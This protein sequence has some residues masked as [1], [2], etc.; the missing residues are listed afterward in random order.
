[1]ERKELEGVPSC[2][3]QH[4]SVQPILHVFLLVSQQEKEGKKKLTIRMKMSND[5]SFELM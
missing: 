5:K 4:R 1:M 2:Q 3:A